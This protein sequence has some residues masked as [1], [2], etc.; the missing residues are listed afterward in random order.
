MVIYLINSL[1]K[2]VAIGPEVEGVSESGGPF[3]VA[4]LHRITYV[5]LRYRLL[6]RTPGTPPCNHGTPV[7]FTHVSYRLARF[8]YPT[9]TRSFPLLSDSMTG[10]ATYGDTPSS[11]RCGLL[12]HSSRS[13]R[14]LKYGASPRTTSG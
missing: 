11:L 2:D 4:S 8:R 13:A 7:K 12:N 10:R 3:S 6:A 5:S 9:F 1:D 14:H